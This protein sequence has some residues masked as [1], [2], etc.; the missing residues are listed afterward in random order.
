M[1]YLL[2]LLLFI[3]PLALAE[4]Y[5]QPPVDAATISNNFTSPDVVT[6]VFYVNTPGTQTLE[7]FKQQ[8]TDH[9]YRL[10]KSGTNPFLNAIT[11]EFI[12]D[13]C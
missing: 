6:T 9:G 7:Q 5:I 8:F 13:W 1:K 11:L 2:L 4:V 12:R 10:I 3:S